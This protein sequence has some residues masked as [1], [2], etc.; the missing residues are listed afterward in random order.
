MT[1]KYCLFLKTRLEFAIRQKILVFGLNSP[2]IT[3]TQIYKLKKSELAFA[4]FTSEVLV[5]I[6]G[7]LMSAL[8]VVVSILYTFCEFSGKQK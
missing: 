7:A 1:I 6:L 5:L 2:P 4:L 8:F 3:P